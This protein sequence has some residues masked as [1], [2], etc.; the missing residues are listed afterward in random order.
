MLGI[1]LTV[2]VW[3]AGEC[4]SS[5]RYRTQEAQLDTILQRLPDPGAKLDSLR[6][7]DDADSAA[8]VEASRRWRRG[9]AAG[10]VAS[11]DS[12]AAKYSV[13][14]ATL[15]VV[16][17]AARVAEGDSARALVDFRRAIAVDSTYAEAHLDVAAMLAASRPAEALASVD[18]ALRLRPKYVLALLARG[19][20][21]IML[22]RPREAI[23]DLK[24]ATELQPDGPAWGVLANAYGAAGDEESA[25]RAW[26]EARRH[27][28]AHTGR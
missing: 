15:F 28:G 18:G 3:L 21:L 7:F 1:V 12:V 17:G 4:S 11:L 6:A 24:R 14:V 25:A 20:L 13:F 22:G 26:E 23:P 10:A 2:V 16:R 9:D 8:I 5:R 19:S 27:P